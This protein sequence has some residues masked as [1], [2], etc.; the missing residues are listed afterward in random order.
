[1]RSHRQAGGS[2]YAPVRL[3]YQ[4][5]PNRRIC[6]LTFAYLLLAARKRAPGVWEAQLLSQLVL[7]QL[8][9]DLLRYLCLILPYC[10]HIIPS[11]PE[12]SV[13]IAELQISKLLVQHKTAL[14]FQIP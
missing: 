5:R 11:A 14:P 6:D 4:Q 10:I 8:L 3:S 9:P 2:P 7:F 1:M 13:P 12:L